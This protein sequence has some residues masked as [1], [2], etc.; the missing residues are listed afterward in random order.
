MN[1]EET[2]LYIRD[3]T[4][5]MREWAISSVANKII[6][7]H[8]QIG[9]SMQYQTEVISE[10]KASRSMDEQV[11]SRMASR[12][13]KQRD[14]GYVSNWN[15]AVHLKATNTLGLPKPMLAKKIADVKNIDYEGA[16]VQPKFDGNRCLIYC[17]NG[18]NKA[19]TRNG[20]P[21]DSI[22]HILQDIEM[23]EGTILDGELY[24]HGHPLQT[25]VSWVKRRQEA[26]L[27]L[28]YHVY[29]VIIDLPY[30]A[31]SNILRQLSFGNSI[32]P[33]YGTI[34]RDYDD[35]IRLFR[36][37]RST[38]YEGAILRWGDQGYEDG[39]RSK[40]LVKVKHWEDD[41]FEVLDV[42][43][44]K[45]YWGVLVC[46]IPNGEYFTVSAPGTMGE[47]TE[48]LLNKENY[49]GKMVTVEYANLTQD[50]IPFHPVAIH[51]RDEIQ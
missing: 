13:S 30:N 48:I 33:V 39:K 6:I 35:L 23:E 29:D 45:D 19:Y 14:K 7:R 9:G 2:I 44:S 36:T 17:E 27:K 50:G 11:M 15:K 25:I 3:N 37:Y 8:G 43:S 1:T 40:S 10:G 46:G 24:C 4:G 34:I 20:K 18:I 31:R 49:I 38:G 47:K 16:I 26:T 12:I 28:K 51:F 42:I 41:E 5:A 21:I 32:S 22:T